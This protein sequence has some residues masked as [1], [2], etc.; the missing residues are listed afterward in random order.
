M[1]LDTSR[2]EQV[3]STSVYAPGLVIQ[4]TKCLWCRTVT[5][6]VTSCSV[7]L[8]WRL[9]ERGLFRVCAE[10]ELWRGSSSLLRFWC[11]SSPRFLSHW[12]PQPR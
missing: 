9:V 6:C 11:R 3:R 1:D 7:F 8:C 2:L 4:A 10:P 5:F 12:T